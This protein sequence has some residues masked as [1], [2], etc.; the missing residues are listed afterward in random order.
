MRVPIAISALL[1]LVACWLI[2]PA[3]AQ[4]APAKADP[5]APASNL[6]YWLGQAETP[7][8][9]PA[10]QPASQPAEPAASE[11]LRADALP[12]AVRL[13]DGRTLAGGLYTTRGKCW[14]VWNE[15]RH[16]WQR[17][18]FLTVLSITAV[19]V[20]RKLEPKW[21]WKAMGE[22]ERV[23]TGE[24]YPTCRLQW[25]FELIDGTTLTGAVKGQ[26][27]WLDASGRQ[28]GPFVLHERMKGKV[29]QGLDDLVHLQRLVV[30]RRTMQ[31]VLVGAADAADATE[32]DK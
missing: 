26:P 15:D 1:A 9:S 6:D 7:A 12:G 28:A 24:T 22:P 19:V 5:N 18:P 13:S 16:R 32:A 27:I 11:S 17:V 4:V 20:E 29:G 21:R 2:A 31:Q 23:Y 8:T 25:R 14:Q 30:S 3:G 10:T